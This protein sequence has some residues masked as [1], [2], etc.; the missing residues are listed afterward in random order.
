MENSTEGPNDVSEANAAPHVSSESISEEPAQH[1]DA[2]D[3]VQSSVVIKCVDEVSS[4]RFAE[5]IYAAKLLRHVDWH[6]EVADKL[7]RRANADIV[8]RSMANA[9]DP[10]KGVK[11]TGSKLEAA[12]PPPLK[13]VYRD[14]RTN[15]SGVAGTLI[16]DPKQVDAIVDRW[17]KI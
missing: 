13:S 11:H 9:D 1:E 4:V 12:P 3:I 7:S 2:L 5:P 10:R 14:A 8:H 17:Q 6:K 16:A 15:D